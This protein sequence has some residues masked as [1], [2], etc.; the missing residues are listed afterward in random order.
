[1]YTCKQ[2][3]FR[4]DILGNMC[5]CSLNYNTDNMEEK[6]KYFNTSWDMRN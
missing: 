4:E 6:L 2:I 3:R 1:M 5:W